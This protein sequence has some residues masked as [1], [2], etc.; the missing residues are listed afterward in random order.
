M[1]INVPIK[2]LL[3]SYTLHQ[4]T[5][6][7]STGYIIFVLLILGVGSE[8]SVPVLTGGLLKGLSHDSPFNS[9]QF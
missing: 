3:L 7:K 5:S 1:Y 9:R 4:R 2:E 6:E 8:L